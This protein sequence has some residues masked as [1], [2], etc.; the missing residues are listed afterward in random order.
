MCLMLYIGTADKLSLR[1]SSDLRIETVDEARLGV[2][3]WFSSPEV[4]FVGAHTG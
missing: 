3:Q 1:A 2:K 4:H